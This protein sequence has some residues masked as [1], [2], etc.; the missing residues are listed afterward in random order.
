ME[1]EEMRQLMEDQ[2]RQSRRLRARIREL[3][4]ERHGPIAIVGTG[5]R[6]P[7][8]I[9][10]PESYWDFLLGDEDAISE[11]PA[12]RPGLRAAH[13]PGDVRP[14][15]SYVDRAA[16]LDDVAD[17]DP[18]FFGISTREAGELDPQQR[19]LLEVAWEAL[20]RAG[21]VVR[22]S[23][24][25]D[26]GVFVGI[27]A[28]EYSER[29]ALAGDRNAIG[30]YFGTG[31]GHCFAAGRLSY[32][33]GL[34]GP[35]LSVDTACSSSLAALHIGVQSLRRHECKYAL[36][37]GTNMIFSAD[38]MVSLCQNQ[39]LAPD[40]RS[41]P[42]TAAA[43]G[44][45][46][47][48]GV[49]MLVLM[50]LDEAR[51]EGRPVL[52]VVRGTAVNHDGRSSGLTV[53][54]GPAQERLLRAALAD[55]GIDAAEVGYVEAHGT[56]TALGDPIEV[57]AIDGVYGT[58]AAGRPSQLVIG[59]VKG[60]LGHLEAAAGMAGLLKVVQMLRRQR[61]PA[62]L[63]P[64]DTDLNP[65]IR[66]Q[67]VNVE[68][69]RAVQPW[70]AGYERL[71]AGISAFGLSGTNAHVLVEA[72]G[73]PQAA[74]ATP[75]R[76]ELV[77]LSARTEAAL[78]EQIDAVRKYL[79]GLP[80]AE[81]ALACHTLRAGRVSFNHRVAVVGTS[82]EELAG[83]LSTAEAR[84][85]SAGQLADI[86]LTV[87][88]DNGAYRH[89]DRA[90][91]A[92]AEAFPALAGV[93]RADAEPAR[94]LVRLLQGLG[95]A[96]RLTHATMREREVAARLT[97]RGGGAD[98]VTDDSGASVTLL[99][100]A[101]GALFTA[102]ADLRA[103]SL[104]APGATFHAG[105]PTYPFQRTRLWIDEA[106]TRGTAPDL[107]VVA[108]EPRDLPSAGKLTEDEIAT[109]VLAEVV[110]ALGTDDFDA[111]DSFLDAGGDSFTAMLVVKGVR[112]RFA[113][114]IPTEEFNADGAISDQ[115]RVVAALVV[116][117]FGKE[118]GRA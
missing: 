53:P 110:R 115:V 37:G 32:A 84:E 100:A 47:G 88:D 13:A 103:A 60:R 56:G 48:E 16:F 83:R 43:D 78:T 75:G 97:W 69:A 23:E 33:L 99:L 3:E 10:D 36:V 2:L 113:V 101:L 25:L 89:V 14:G 87:R 40:G 96:A 105:V 80:A 27:M 55:A 58:G 42:F 63:L 57:G 67:D 73:A 98:L 108:E 111:T 49:V 38:L 21:I 76:P 94:R 1:L 72:A 116:D 82:A 44:Y 8:D 30:P 7:R 52:A 5:L 45:G 90:L 61:I 18:A 24:P 62:S 9:N 22:R 107:D 46:R 19:L 79:I 117:A 118:A 11:I 34:V 86:V 93:C 41:K 64:G 15:H 92:L 12:D 6:L 106:P 70:P 39:A 29:L 50:R 59:S 91:N 109:L 68:V 17:F 51:R 4:D 20:E 54:N 95:I 85:T 74:A 35:A 71:V 102:G 26:A 114:E 104:A 81:I 77:T 31:G 28:S 112:E 65:H 66:W